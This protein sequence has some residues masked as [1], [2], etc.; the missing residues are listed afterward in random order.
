MSNI[1]RTGFGPSLQT[2]WITFTLPTCDSGAAMNFFIRRRSDMP[3]DLGF[4]RGYSSST[5]ANA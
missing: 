5:Y 2:P 3:E 4:R 1:I